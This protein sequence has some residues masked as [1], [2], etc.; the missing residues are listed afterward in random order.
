MLSGLEGVNSSTEYIVA[1]SS[2]SQSE[3]IVEHRGEGS[4]EGDREYD[5]GGE[6]FRK[7]MVGHQNRIL[8]PL[9]LPFPVRLVRK[10]V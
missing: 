1:S 3:R 5:E 8:E 10:W 7:I 9:E 2:A 4:G 6:V